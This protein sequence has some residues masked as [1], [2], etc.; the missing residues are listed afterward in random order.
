M[1]PKLPKIKTNTKSTTGIIQG[2]RS[3]GRNEIKNKDWRKIQASN[4][5]NRVA[6]SANEES[7]V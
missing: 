3:G 2:V 7:T 4:P 5:R 6:P 1:E